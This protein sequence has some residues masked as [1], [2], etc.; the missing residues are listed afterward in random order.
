MTLASHPTMTPF[1][2]TLRKDSHVRR[3]EILPDANGWRVVEHEDSRVVRD[4]L[5]DDWHR[6]ERARRAF[7]VEMN[8]LR[9]EGWTD[10]RS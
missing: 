2:K 8:S 10:A 4:T 5:Y 1:A 6:V 9:S 3:Y 7:V